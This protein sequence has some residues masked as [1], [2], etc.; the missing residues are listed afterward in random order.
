MFKLVLNTPKSSSWNQATEKLLVK[1]IQIPTQSE[2]AEWKI[3]HPPKN[4]V[5]QQNPEFPL[6]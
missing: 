3:S 1:I 5:H 4:F 2:I 6:G